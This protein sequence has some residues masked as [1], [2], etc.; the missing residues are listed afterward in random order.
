MSY[1][2][3]LNQK[4]DEDLKTLSLY[5]EENSVPIITDEGRRF[6]SQMIRLNQAKRVLEIG[7]AIGY[8][9]IAMAKNDPSIQI[10]T[11]ER[12]PSMQKKAKASFEGTGLDN[13]ITLIEADALE[14][15]E[16]ALKGPFDLLFIDAAKAQSER[17]FEKYAPLV[18]KGG[19]VITDNLLFHGLL[20]ADAPR[21]KNRNTRQLIKKIDRFNHWV[22]NCPGYDT[23]IYSIGDG[24]SLSIKRID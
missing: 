18:R 10:V 23:Q 17:F 14:Y 20:E 22:L 11:I 5:A 6:L 15:D 7:T 8:S 19:L 24:M 12:D 1:L 9:A 2:D 13:Q 4:H 21:S 3:D 16:N